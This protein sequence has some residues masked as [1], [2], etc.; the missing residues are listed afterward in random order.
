MASSTPAAPSSTSR[1]SELREAVGQARQEI[2][3][4]DAAASAPGGE[5]A[6]AAPAAAPAAAVPAEGSSVE[7]VKEFLENAT[8]EEI[9][10]IKADP[11][12]AKLYNS[13]LRDYRAKTEAIASRGR[14]L[15]EKEETL[16]QQEEEQAAARKLFDAIRDNPDAMI[17]ALA[18]RRGITIKEAEEAVEAADEELTKLFGE[19]APAVKPLFDKAVE[20][21]A[22]TV[23]EEALG[24]VNEFI[25]NSILE[26]ERKEIGNDIKEFV[27]DLKASGESITPEVE[28]EMIRLVGLYD[29]S[30]DLPTKDYLRGLYAMASAGK[31][32]SEVTRE[33]V[34]RMTK[35]V[36]DREPADVPTSGATSG[37]AALDPKLNFRQSLAVA[38][39]EVQR[40]TRN[41]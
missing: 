28:K 9:A 12:Q 5:T 2:A 21:R 40:E 6:P 19:D 33:V 27:T 35:A 3:K 37:T 7:E 22:K 38:R 15:D 8:A 34:E 32:K 25:Q 16:R 11:V 17:R 14:E 36:K 29:Q 10:A 26:A 1:M 18:E 31:T 13:M 30:D 39:R 41:R 20:K 4:E 24:P 23:V